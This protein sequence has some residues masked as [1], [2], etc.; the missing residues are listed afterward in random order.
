MIAKKETEAAEPEIKAASSTEQI[1]LSEEN[2]EYS[3]YLKLRY[4]IHRNFFVSILDNSECA[5]YILSSAV[6]NICR[7]IYSY[8][9][10]YNIQK[11]ISC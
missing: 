3:P 5:W 1:E 7:I 9:Y 10:L 2:T 8:F 4:I 6:N 11:I